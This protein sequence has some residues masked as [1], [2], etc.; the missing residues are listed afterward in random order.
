VYDS[1]SDEIRLALLV[2][3]DTTAL[4]TVAQPSDGGSTAAGTSSTSRRGP[5]VEFREK[6]L[7]S[8]QGDPIGTICCNMSSFELK[9][10]HHPGLGSTATSIMIQTDRD[11]L[12]VLLV[13][14]ITLEDWQQTFDSVFELYEKH[15]EAVNSIAPLMMIPCCICCSLPKLAS[16]QKNLQDDWADLCRREQQRYRKA[17]ISVALH[18]EISTMGVGSSRNISNEVVGLKFN[19]PAVAQQSASDV[20]TSSEDPTQQLNTLHQIY[21]TGGLTSSEYDAAK[22]KILAKM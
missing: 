3:L 20:G 19:V 16:M 21:K 10:S 5:E 12:P 11:E 4:G 14:R 6:T 7:C 2:L 13:N 1:G 8:H 15:L 22:A 17:G 9:P 18:R